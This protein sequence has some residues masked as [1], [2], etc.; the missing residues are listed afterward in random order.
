MHLR[1]RT[2]R[3]LALA[4]L[5]VAAPLTVGGTLPATADTVRPAMDAVRPAAAP[6]RQAAVETTRRTTAE[7]TPAAT[8]TAAPEIPDSPAGRQLRW[9][10]DATTRAPLTADELGQHVNADYLKQLTVDGLNR[11]LKG[12]AG[13]R[14]EE[15]TRTDPVLL[16]GTTVLAGQRFDVRLG[17]DASEKINYLLV[18]P[19]IPPAPTGWAQ[20]DARLREIAPRTGFLAAEIDR[21]GRC[22][23]VHGVGADTARPLGSVFKLYVLGAVADRIHAGKL[24]W[25][26]RLTVTPDVK[27]PDADGLGAR[28]DGSTVTVREAAKLMISI[29]DNTAA[30]LLLKTAGRKAVEKKVRQW[31]G[32]AERN[33]PFLTTRELF[34][35]KGVDYPRHARAYLA[36]DTQ[37]RRAYLRDVVAGLPLSKIKV[38][39]RP[40]EIDTLEW[41][42][43]PRDVCR[44]YAGLLKQNDD[45]LDEVLSVN[46]AGLGLDPAAWPTVW[47]KG[48][49]ELG[50][51]DM[52]FLGR[53]AKGK[54]YVVTT[55]ASDTRAPLDEGT[56]APEIIS[57]S[58]GGF[59]LVK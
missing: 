39:E 37:G 44:A 59:G 8:A 22:E 30:D 12:L 33:L 58:R 27:I 19:S 40:R 18:T 2:T 4:A 32:H 13:I 15:L 14:L 57:L 36:R 25:E 1:P 7:A 5:A 6:A 11:F 10:L 42:G 45:R 53:T 23:T 50:V 9:F 46:D 49:S 24:G 28:P 41:F 51:L 3:A 38:W 20:L 16:T 56:V 21:R 54:T 34:L 26:T 52:A 29:S 17:V 35:L 48:G 43:S 55:L 47:Y 31:S